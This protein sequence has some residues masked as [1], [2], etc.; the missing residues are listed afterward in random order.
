MHLPCYLHTDN[1]GV[2]CCRRKDRAIIFA[3]LLS[4]A[5]NHKPLRKRGTCVSTI[6]T[7]ISAVQ[8]TPAAGGLGESIPG[9]SSTKLR[10]HD[11]AERLGNVI[12]EKS[13]PYNLI[14]LTINESRLWFIKPLIEEYRKHWLGK[15][16]EA[17][18]VYSPTLITKKEFWP[19]AS[20]DQG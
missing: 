12:W 2:F 5:T 15:Y 13:A 6:V 4:E 1:P 17:T 8:Q 19:Q 9:P 20:L 14:I 10:T 7:W 11:G 3:T 18:L 16:T